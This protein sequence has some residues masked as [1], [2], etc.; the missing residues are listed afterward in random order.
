V[1]EDELYGWGWM[2]GDYPE[3]EQS[4]FRDDVHNNVHHIESALQALGLSLV[5]QREGG[6]NVGYSIEHG[7]EP[8]ED[9]DEEL[10]YQTYKVGNRVYHVSLI[11]RV[12]SIKS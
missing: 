10:W 3:D 12:M 7:I 6:H 9:D 4:N 8:I 1:A 5:S 11:K 2:E